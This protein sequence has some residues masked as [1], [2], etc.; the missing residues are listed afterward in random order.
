MTSHRTPPD[1]KRIQRAAAL[2]GSRLMLVDSDAD[3]LSLTRQWI[4]WE[5]GPDAEVAASGDEALDVLGARSQR[6]DAVAVWPWLADDAIVDFYGILRRCSSPV[7]LVAVTALTPAELGRP[8]RLAG[9]AA[10]EDTGRPQKLIETLARVVASDE[11]VAAIV[12]R[13][14]APRRLSETWARAIYGT[15]PGQRFHSDLD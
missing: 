2:A 11:T 6:F 1:S 10:V 15:A 13:R 14:M 8:G 3:R 12:A 7:H 5:G 4:A 9:V